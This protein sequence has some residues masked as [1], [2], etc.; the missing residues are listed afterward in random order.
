MKKLYQSSSSTSV[1]NYASIPTWPSNSLATTLARGIVIV[2]SCTDPLVLAVTLPS[3]L[4]VSRDRILLRSA[5]EDVVVWLVCPTENLSSR[6]VVQRPHSY[7]RHFPL[8]PLL[9]CQRTNRYTTTHP[10]HWACPPFHHLLDGRIHHGHVSK[11]EVQFASI[12]LRDV[13]DL[14]VIR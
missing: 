4:V 2:S 12:L 10:L 14:H 11:I 9:P 7:R 8:L 1:C 3:L 5:V 13:F 6:G